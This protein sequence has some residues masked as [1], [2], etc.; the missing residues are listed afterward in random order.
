MIMVGVHYWLYSITLQRW[1]C[2]NTKRLDAGEY[3][4]YANGCYLWELRNGDLEFHD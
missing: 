4:D 3:P 2:K 1:V